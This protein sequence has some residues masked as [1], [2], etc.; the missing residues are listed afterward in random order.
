MWRIRTGVQI[1]RSEFHIHIFLDYVR[2]ES[3][4]EKK[5]KNKKN[6][7][8]TES[9][10]TTKGSYKPKVLPSWNYRVFD[11]TTHE[12]NG[13][14]NSSES[15]LNRSILTKIYYISGRSLDT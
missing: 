15:G 7:Q 14:M 12:V 2:V 13:N 5:K 10:S 8:R 3:Y 9:L 1:F 11:V 6:S 4:L